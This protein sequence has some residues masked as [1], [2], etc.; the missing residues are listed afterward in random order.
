MPDDDPENEGVKLLKNTFAVGEEAFPYIGDLRDRSVTELEILHGSLN[1][2]EANPRTYFYFRS[3]DFIAKHVKK[4]DRWM[5]R[6]AAP[7][8]A[9][10]VFVFVMCF[11]CLLLQRRF[12]RKACEEGRPMDGT[13]CNAIPCRFCFRLCFSCLLL[14]RRF[15]SEKREYRGP[16]DVT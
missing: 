6:G 2:P 5:V 12:H 13:W 10:V 3:V 16:V 9:V 14:Q 7:F 1:D 11:S 4:E 8:R 15:H